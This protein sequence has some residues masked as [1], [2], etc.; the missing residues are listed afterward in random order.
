MKVLEKSET[1]IITSIITSVMQMTDVQRILLLTY[2][3]GLLDGG[4][5]KKT[6]ADSDSKN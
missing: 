2:G 1:E 3:N 5:L 4:K 6:E